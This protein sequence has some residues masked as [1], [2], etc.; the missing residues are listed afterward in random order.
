M[1]TLE[2]AERWQNDGIRAVAVHPGINPGTRFG[3]DTPVILRTVGPLIARVL[4]ITSTFEQVCERYAM[5]SFGDVA[6]GT[7]LAEGKVTEPP[8]QARDTSI[9][10]ALWQLIEQISFND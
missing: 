4:G 8:G 7:F 2:Q 5:A 9:R 6:N 3:R 10:R 1:I